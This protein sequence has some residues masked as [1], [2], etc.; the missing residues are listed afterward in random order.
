LRSFLQ[1]IT[2][3]NKIRTI[4]I[5]EMYY[6][7]KKYERVSNRAYAESL[8]YYIIALLWDQG[9]VCV[10]SSNEWTALAKI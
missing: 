5:P 7:I 2:A 4:T 6:L 8:I 10:G 1:S 9:I 3:E